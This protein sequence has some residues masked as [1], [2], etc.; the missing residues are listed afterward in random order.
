MSFGIQ[1]L[2][3][4]ISIKYLITSIIPSQGFSAQAFQKKK[5]QVKKNVLG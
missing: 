3:K 5:I 4:M 2:M 1:F